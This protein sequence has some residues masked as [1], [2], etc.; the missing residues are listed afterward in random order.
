MI[1]YKKG[2]FANT[3][4]NISLLNWYF[5]IVCFYEINFL[6]PQIDFSH[7]EIFLILNLL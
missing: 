4:F 3:F 2:F 6:K 5:K 1:K 7:V